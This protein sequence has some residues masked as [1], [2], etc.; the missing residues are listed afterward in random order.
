MKTCLA[1]HRVNRFL[2]GRLDTI[3]TTGQSFNLHRARPFQEEEPQER[4]SAGVATGQKTMIAE[5][6]GV[7]V[8]KVGNQTLPLIMIERD[9]LIIVIG[10]VCHDNHRRLRKRQQAFFLRRDG[11][12]IVRMGMNDGMRVFALSVHSAM[13]RKPGRVDHVRRVHNDVALKVHLHQA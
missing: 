6:H 7:F 9:P 3:P 2:R 10:K 4:I 11:H 1:R 8:S 5:D 12:P 13:D